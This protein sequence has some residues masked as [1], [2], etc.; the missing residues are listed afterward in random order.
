MVKT[1]QLKF[2][3]KTYKTM[4]IGLKNIKRGYGMGR[5]ILDKVKEQK[6]LG[7]I[8]DIQLK[9]HAEVS[10]TEAA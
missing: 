2:N 10:E 8:I 6:D 7:V 1:Q 9:L 5:I 3:A 4:H